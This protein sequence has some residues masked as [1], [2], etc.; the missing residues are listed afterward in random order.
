MTISGGYTKITT[1]VMT[2]SGSFRKLLIKGL[3][4]AKFLFAE[5]KK[6]GKSFSGGYK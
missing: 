4:H 2:T 3:S 6:A 5:K 1:K